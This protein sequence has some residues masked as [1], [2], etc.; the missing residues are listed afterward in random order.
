[1]AE[2]PD[3]VDGDALRSEVWEQ[4]AAAL[5]ALVEA[6]ESFAKARS[7]LRRVVTEAAWSV[8]LAAAR[9]DLAAFGPFWWRWFKGDY[10]RARAILR[11]IAKAEPPARSATT[12]WLCSIA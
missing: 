4:R 2:L 7:E 8:E 12:S 5:E 11:A 6:G 9:Q 3:A 1:M 10:R